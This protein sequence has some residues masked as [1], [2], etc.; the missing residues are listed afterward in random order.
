M[1][2]EN[3][4]EGLLTCFLLKRALGRVAAMNQRVGILCPRSPGGIVGKG[5]SSSEEENIPLAE[6]AGRL[7]A[8][9]RRLE[10]EQGLVERHKTSDDETSVVSD[11]AMSVAEVRKKRGRGKSSDSLRNILSAILSVL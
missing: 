10:G 9:E 8:R 11:E 4:I 2:Q 7:K 3:L 1:I 6:L 5:T